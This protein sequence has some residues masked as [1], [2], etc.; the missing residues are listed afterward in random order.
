[1]FKIENTTIRLTRGDICTLRISASGENGEPYVFKSGDVVR[2]QIMK[3]R[4]VSNIVLSKSINVESETETV[5]ISLSSAETRLDSLINRPKIYWYEI[6]LN[7]ETSPQT[8]IGYDQDG[9]KEFII[10]P[11]GADVSD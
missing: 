9:A 8:I 7:P 1:M 10:Y 5:E 2:L 3:E 6:E 4:D 11:E